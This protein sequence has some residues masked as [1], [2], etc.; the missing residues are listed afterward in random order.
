M[1]DPRIRNIRG[2]WIVS[3]VPR[4]PNVEV[5][6]DENSATLPYGFKSFA[7]S[8]TEQASSRSPTSR[9]SGCSGCGTISLY[10]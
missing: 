5:L 9:L 8:L 7:M 2:L 6:V 1:L 3:L 4:D 10:G